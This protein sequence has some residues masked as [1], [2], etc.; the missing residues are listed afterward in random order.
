MVAYFVDRPPYLQDFQEWVEDEFHLINRWRTSH[1]QYVGKKFFFIEF[2]KSKDRDTSQDSA[3]WFYGRRYFYTFPWI[4]NF[5]ITTSHFNMLHVWIE[6]PYRS[7]LLENARFKLAKSLGEVLYIRG[8]E[9][10]SYSNDKAC[11]L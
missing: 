11:I 4:P 5:D 10:N 8:N 9:R 7:L 1:T 3:P 6:I 2:A